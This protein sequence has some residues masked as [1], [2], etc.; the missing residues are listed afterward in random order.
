MLKMRRYIKIFSDL[1][2]AIRNV[3]AIFVLIWPMTHST[4][5]PDHSQHSTDKPNTPVP[6]I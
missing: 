1:A 5:L 3:V 6:K 4:A 2:S